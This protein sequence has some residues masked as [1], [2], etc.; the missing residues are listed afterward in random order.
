MYRSMGFIVLHEFLKTLSTTTTTSVITR[1]RSM[2]DKRL[3]VSKPNLQNSETGQQQRHFHSKS[4]RESHERLRHFIFLNSHPIQYFAPMYAEM[5]K[6][7]NLNVTVLYCSRQGVDDVLDRQFNANVRWDI[8]ILEGYRHVF[9]KNY[10]PHPTLY[11]FWGLQNWGI[12]QHLWRSPKS[13]LVVNGWGY[14][15]NMV[16]IVVGK[17]MGHRICLRGESPLLLEK[18]KTAR[19]L[20][21][22]K[23]VLG[24]LLFRF[25]D[26]FL[27]IG[28]QNKQFYQFYQIPESKLVSSPYSV[29]NQRFQTFL[30]KNKAE[31]QALRHELGLPEHKIIVLYSGKYIAKKR[32]M[33]LLRASLLLPSEKCAIVMI[34]EGELRPEM[35]AFIREHQLQNIILTGFVNQ[36]E[37][38]KYYAAS[39]V[40]VMCSDANETWGLAVNEAMNLGL[41]VVLSD[42]IGCARD[43]VEEGKNGFIY[44]MGDVAVLGEKLNLVVS[45]DDFRENAG[46]RSLEIIERYSY[47]QIIANLKNL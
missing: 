47:T 5:A 4:Y 34:G 28:Q 25:V 26:Y 16:A 15:I 21:F 9:L 13:V 20:R 6:D 36:S 11:S 23:V 33:D 44:P 14:L 18:Q 35:E 3:M 38:P 30:P 29:D 19:S 31:K 45:D 22:R 41:A 12:I 32:P 40:L 8:P 42:Q 46:R 27:Y 2:G 1:E 10:A 39:D 37:I 43:L 24:K 17:I 7:E